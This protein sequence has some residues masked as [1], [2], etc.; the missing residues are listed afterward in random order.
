MASSVALHSRRPAEPDV[1]SH[2]PMFPS[3]SDANRSSARACAIVL[4]SVLAV[5]APRLH[6]QR[7]PAAAPWSGVPSG[8]LAIGYQA[9]SLRDSTR[10]LLP[11]TAGRREPRPR[12]I[13]VRVWYPAA[14]AARR[15][16]PLT[17]AGIIGRSTGEPDS[18]LAERTR[19]LHRYAAQRYDRAGGQP[20]VAADTIGLTVR[21]LA[22]ATAAI[23]DAPPAAGRHPLVVFAGGTA[24]SLDENVALWEHLASHGYV[25]AVIATI[26]TEQGIEQAY[27]PD[28]A[29]G[30]ETVTRDLEVVLA[31]MAARA[32]VDGQRVAAAGFSFGGAAALALAARNARV[33]AVIGLDPSFIAGRHLAML[34]AHPLFDARRVDVPILD[35][36]R[37]DTATVDLALLEAASRSA[38]TSIE[39]TG[40]DHVDFNSYMLLYAPLLQARSARPA[41]DSAL[42]FKADAYR[43][44]VQTTRIFLDEVLAGRPTAE[45]RLGTG[46]VW[47]SMPAGALRVRRW[48]SG[49]PS[50]R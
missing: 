10:T 18:G 2:H 11:D 47:A 35:F 17:F 34:R 24:H 22:T 1:L 6:A 37:A 33:R 49:A 20:L 7:A 19:G 16:A 9:L 13:P 5:T 14:R 45:S 50:P 25:V 8:P 15:A 26:A 32:N 42:A 28:D 48:P 4:A 23:A 27:L 43:A 29:A 21:A 31:R 44:M 39:I 36:H 30:L 46:P 12:V 38:R 41:R 3:L 40:L